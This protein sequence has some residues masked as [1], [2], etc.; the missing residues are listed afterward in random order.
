MKRGKRSKLQD[1]AYA[2][3]LIVSVCYTGCRPNGSTEPDKSIQ[4]REV[5]VPSQIDVA[6]RGNVTISGKGFAAGDKIRL[7]L[8]TDE[9]RVHIADILSFDDHS[10]IFALPDGFTPG[11]YKI[12]LVRGSQELTLGASTINIIVGGTLPDIAGKTIKGLVHSNGAGVPGV[13]VSD[14]YEVTVTDQ[15]G[16]YYLASEKKNGFVFIS[17]PGNYE[18][19]VQ[20]NFPQFFKRLTGGSAVEQKDFSLTPAAGN[21]HTI[22][23]LSDWHLANRNNDLQQFGSGFLPDVN[24]AIGEYSA[25]GSKVYGL[26]LG[27]MSWD[28]YW[29]ENNFGLVEY[30]AEM[31]KVNCAMFN[32]IGNHDNDPYVQGDLASEVKYR[33]IIGPTYYSFNLGEVHCVVLDNIEYVNTGGA[34]GQIGER[35]YNDVITAAQIEWLKKDL[36]TLKDK[37]APVIIAMHAPLY[38]TPTLNAAGGQVNSLSLNNAGQFLSA[39]QGLSEV[40]ILTGHIHTNYTVAHSEAVTEYNIGAVCATWWWTGRSGYANNHIG[41]DGSP[42]GYGVMEIDG[43]NVKWHYK[44]IGKPKSY[45]FRSYDLNKV[46]ITAEKYA[47]NA[48]GEALAEYAGVYASPNLGN[49]VLINVWGYGPGW[50]I[51]VREGNTPLQV[52]QVSGLDPLHIISYEAKRL[53]AGAV[54]TASFVTGNTVHLFKV[55][56]SSP[57]STLEIKVTDRSGAVYS[58]TMVRPKEFTYTID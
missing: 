10:A 17:V 33:E 12:V 28:A 16:V 45:Q 7:I 47:P 23:A 18:A 8:A 42:G 39:I 30:V 48:T 29:Y 34:Q 53:N 32:V 24:A 15:N 27:D 51:E 14:G 2:V 55:T 57:V 4:I 9:S 5:S 41:K 25:A 49:E 44:S 31:K 21:K 20:D 52:K 26:A 22:L 54:P 50:S 58:E 19:P 56:A 1:L 13:V 43:R 11:K 36:A 6:A 37:S 35:N 38:R 46:H 3:F 40:H